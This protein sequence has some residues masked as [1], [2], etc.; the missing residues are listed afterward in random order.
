MKYQ[1]ITPF[2]VIAFISLLGLYDLYVYLLNGQTVSL[3]IWEQSARVPLLPALLGTVMG[4]FYLD[5]NRIT[6]YVKL[7]FEIF[8]LLIVIQTASA[9]V[10][11]HSSFGLFLWHFSKGHTWFPFAF[12]LLF[13][14]LYWSKSGYVDENGTWRKP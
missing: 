10:F 13:G 11:S 4:H 12:G 7:I 8:A 6:L 1:E 5:K 9:M 2:V 3:Y 14:H